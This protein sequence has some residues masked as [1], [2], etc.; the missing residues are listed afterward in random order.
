MACNCGILLA[1]LDLN[2]IDIFKQQRTCRVNGNV[3]NHVLE[4]M[5]AVHK[6][7]DIGRHIELDT[8]CERPDG[9]PTGLPKGVFDR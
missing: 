4:I 2:W 8:T 6:S 5:H 7:S 9:V 3:A 1:M